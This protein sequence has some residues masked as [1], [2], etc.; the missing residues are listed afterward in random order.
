MEVEPVRTGVVENAGAV[1]QLIT[2]KTAEASQGTV[3][4]VDARETRTLRID[5]R[6]LTSK[7]GLEVLVVVSKIRIVGT[8]VLI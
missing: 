5:A 4:E 6:I 1:D 2:S 8:S 3:V 7:T